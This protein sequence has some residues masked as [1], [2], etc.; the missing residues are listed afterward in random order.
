MMNMAAKEQRVRYIDQ[1][2]YIEEFKQFKNGDKLLLK[3][4]KDS[5]CNLEK[6]ISGVKN[7]YV[8]DKFKTSLNTLRGIANDMKVHKF[9][10]GNGQPFYAKIKEVVDLKRTIKMPYIGSAYR[11]AN[12]AGYQ[13]D[14]IKFWKQYSQ[15]YPEVLS[16]NNLKLIE[17]GK[18]PLVDKQWIKYNSNH[19]SFIGETLE[20]HHLNNTDIAAG[21]P[22]SLHRGKNNKEL[23]HVD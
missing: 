23:M 4:L 21:V 19:K 6:Y 11:N 16:K 3:C 17:E 10:D 18:S 9:I 22:M 14:A 2:K 13:R 7:T 1:F 20:H 12:A 8:G 15:K 5:G